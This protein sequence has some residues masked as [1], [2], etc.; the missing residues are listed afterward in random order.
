MPFT[1][2]PLCS[3]LSVLWQTLVG[4]DPS[5]HDF[6]THVP[7][8]DPLKAM[9][10]NFR[11][12]RGWIRWAWIG[13]T[14]RGDEGRIQEPLQLLPLVPWETC[15]APQGGKEWWAPQHT[16]YS[17]ALESE[18]VWKSVYQ[19]A[20]MLYISPQVIYYCHHI[21]WK[22]FKHYFKLLYLPNQYTVG[23]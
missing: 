4:P 11:F 15:S 22:P 2:C 23:S 6:L 5:L 7:D 16:W 12:L 14:N 18:S 8:K 17:R 10:P 1:S 21:C 3:L 19:R 13:K 9:C 20:D